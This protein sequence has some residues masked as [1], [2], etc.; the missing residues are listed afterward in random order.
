M[1][2]LYTIYIQFYYS[3][4]IGIYVTLYSLGPLIFWCDTKYTHSILEETHLR[5]PDCAPTEHI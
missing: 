2:T 3:L 4:Y 1:V 5:H